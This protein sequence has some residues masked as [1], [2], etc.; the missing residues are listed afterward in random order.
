MGSRPATSV[1]CQLLH[2]LQPKA[3]AYFSLPSSEV[4]ESYTAAPNSTEMPLKANL[5]TELW[6]PSPLPADA[7]GS[8]RTPAQTAKE[9]PATLPGVRHSHPYLGVTSAVWVSRQEKGQRQHPEERIC[10]LTASVLTVHQHRALPRWSLTA[11]N[12]QK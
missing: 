11:A 10:R 8:Q 2:D 3:G 6:K 9:P 12:A 7:D 5:R 1:M 4:P